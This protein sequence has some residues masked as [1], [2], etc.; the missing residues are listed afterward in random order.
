MYTLYIYI[1]SSTPMVILDNDG[2]NSNDNRIVCSIKVC[3][4]RGI[5][6]DM[7]MGYYNN[8]NDNS[9]NNMS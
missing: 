1:K 3:N 7:I 8:I 6:M 4:N 5:I 2:N 9:N